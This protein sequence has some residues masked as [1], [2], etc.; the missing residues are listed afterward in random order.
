MGESVQPVEDDEEVI[1]QAFAMFMHQIYGAINA[2][3][4]HPDEEK[5]AVTLE[6]N[7]RSFTWLL[8]G[9]ESNE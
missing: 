5:L 3:G 9:I 6:E 4:A 7:I 8:A 2:A 1:A